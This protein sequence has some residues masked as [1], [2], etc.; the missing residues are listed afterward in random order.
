MKHEPK[1]E[2]KQGYFKGAGSVYKW[3]DDGYHTF[4]I[5][6]NINTYRKAKKYVRVHIE[7]NKYRIYKDEARE[8]YNKYKSKKQLNENILLVVVSKDLLKTR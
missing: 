6:I 4:G 7:G 3:I 5:G 8:F 2:I 1:V